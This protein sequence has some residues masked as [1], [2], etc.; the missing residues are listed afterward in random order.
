MKKVWVILTCMLCVIIIMAGNLH[1]QIKTGSKGAAKVLNLTDSTEPKPESEASPVQKEV[2]YSKNLP[3]ELAAKIKTAQ[4]GG[5]P[6]KFVMYGSETTSSEQSD[7]PTLLQ[8]RLIEAYGEGVFEISIF[9]ETDKTSREVI[10]GDLYK[11]VIEQNPDLVLLEPFILKDN[12]E[13]GILNTLLNVKTIVGDIKNQN[14]ETIIM[15]QPPHPLYGAKFYPK[16]VAEFK[17]FA[18]NE[19]FLYLDHW[20]NWPAAEDETLKEYLSEEDSK[21][22][23]KGNAVWAEYLIDFF[24]AEK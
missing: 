5:K 23:E 4:E 12:G 19:D 7:W 18:E 6:V 1:W 8:N 11:K 13:I 3:K 17:E 9:S 24:V 22:N 14:S 21:P 16:E 15:L 2:N 20:V 10:N